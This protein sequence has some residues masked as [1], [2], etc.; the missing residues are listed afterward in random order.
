[1]GTRKYVVVEQPI[2]GTPVYKVQPVTRG[3][4]RTLH[5]NLLLPLGVKLEPDYTSDDSILE[6]NYSSSDESV[7]MVDSKSKVKDKKS[8]TTSSIDNSQTEMKSEKFQS[9]EEKHVEFDSRLEISPDSTLKSDTV[10]SP[11]LNNVD[12]EDESVGERSHPDVEDSSDNVI[13]A[14]VSLPSQF[15]LPISDDSSCDEETEV[16]ELKSEAE[17]HDTYQ[18]E[19]MLS[20]NPC[21]SMTQRSVER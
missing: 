15:L 1:M 11:D 13:P 9:K 12:V 18:E 7:V 6:E 17:I 14:D 10:V 20:V 16:T 8:L 19:E 21:F 2:A 3:N 5:R 4:I